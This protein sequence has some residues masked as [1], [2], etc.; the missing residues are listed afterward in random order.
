M[1]SEIVAKPLKLQYPS[2][3]DTIVGFLQTTSLGTSL[4]I[5]LHLVEQLELLCDLV[6]LKPLMGQRA[7]TELRAVPETVGG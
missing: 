4:E 2:A 3:P 5:L 7:N 6:S 1:F